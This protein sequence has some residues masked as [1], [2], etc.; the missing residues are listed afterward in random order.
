MLIYLLV[1]A[2][3]SMLQQNYHKNHYRLSARGSCFC[4]VKYSNYFFFCMSASC[5]NKMCCDRQHLVGA[6]KFTSETA[7]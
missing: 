5:Y 1:C 2:V 3:K 7:Y 6:E 4:F